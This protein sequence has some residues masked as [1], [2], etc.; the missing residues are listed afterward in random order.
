MQEPHE[1]AGL[2]RVVSST[3]G[4]DLGLNEPDSDA[5][6]RRVLF[7]RACRS[8]VLRT[9]VICTGIHLIVGWGLL[10]DW[11]AHE[12]LA[13]CL[14]RLS[15]PSGY[16]GMPLSMISMY[17][18]DAA[19][20]ATV[21]CSA[22]MPRMMAVQRGELPY[23]PPE[24]LHR[25][26]LALLFPRGCGALPR[27]S[28]LLGVA[29]VWGTLTG[30]VGLLVA[31]ACWLLHVSTSSVDFCVPG[32]PYIGT[33]T[34][35]LTLEAAAV[36]AGSFCLWCS[37]AADPKA[38]S[39]FE[40]LEARREAELSAARRKA[41]AFAA[42]QPL[43]A[44][45]AGVGLYCA[46]QVR[47]DHGATP[48]AVWVAGAALGVAAL[49]SCAL[50]LGVALH[51]RRHGQHASTPLR[52]GMV[53]AGYLSLLVSCALGALVLS[54]VAALAQQ[55][56]TEGVLQGW[57]WRKPMAPPFS[58]PLEVARAA[59]D[60]LHRLSAAC[61]VLCALQAAAAAL[62]LALLALP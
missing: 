39:V 33:R 49:S 12:P 24:A 60:A 47:A 6:L 31:L 34:C 4:L 16:G 40:R 25:G 15:H 45:A 3:S 57:A 17:P 38:L 59:S 21:V 19:L 1:E 13:V 20:L 26:A 37:K 32:W 29:L 55:A 43:C 28:S 50:G 23:L 44:A 52:P 9:I 54:A 46:L 11:G 10:T 22:Q 2:P 8:A 61:A 35:L 5:V 18:T 48:R 41:A 56:A 30:A 27:L 14:I 53:A 58:G 7:S 42:L 62:R 51:H 36:C